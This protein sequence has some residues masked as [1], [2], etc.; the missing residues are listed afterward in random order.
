MK[1]LIV[2]AAIIAGVGLGG[3]REA[4]ADSFT[5]NFCGFVGEHDSCSE[6]HAGITEWSIAFTD[7]AGGDDNDYTAVVTLT[8]TN[9]GSI[10]MDSFDWTAGMGFEALPALTGVTGDGTATAAS[11]SVAIGHVNSSG[12]DGC[13]SV[14]GF[15]QACAELTAAGVTGPDINGTQTWTFSVNFADA[16]GQI[17][18]TSNVNLRALF[19]GTAAAGG[20]K[21]SGIISPEGEFQTT[22]TNGGPSPTQTTGPTS[23]PEPALMSLLGAALVALAYRRRR[24]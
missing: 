19:D 21:V 2:A 4:S 5:F 13:E 16:E 14:P 9:A 6:G 1:K 15:D 11:Y 20:T 3:A 7:I 12:A 22:T 17:S 8:S 23:T 10:F 24:S 18:D